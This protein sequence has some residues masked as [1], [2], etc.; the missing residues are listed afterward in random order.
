MLALLAVIGTTGAGRQTG[1]STPGPIAVPASRKATNVAVIPLKGEI[2][3]QGVMAASIRRR[4]EMAE[5]A[6]ADAI[7]IEIDSPGGELGSVLQICN[8]IKSSSI[9]NSVAWINHDAYS[10]GAIVAL[11]CREIVINDPA[12]FGD[13]KVITGGPLGMDPKGLSRDQ[14]KKVLPP[15]IAEVVDSARRHNLEFGAYVWDEYLVQAIV[16]DDVEL[17]LARHKVT[18]QQVCIDR[19]ELEAYF[20]GVSPG[21]PPRLASAPGTGTPADRPFSPRRPSAGDGQVPAGS[22]KLAPIAGDVAARVAAA[23]SRPIIDA[24]TAGEWE[25]VERVT[26]GSAAA[27]FKAADLVHFRI[28]ANDISSVGGVATLVPIRNDADLKAFFGA[29]NLLRYHASWSEGLVVFLTNIFVRGLLIVVFLIAMFV[30]MTH[31]GVIAPGVVAL[32]ALVALLAPPMLIGLAGWWEV[33]AVI[34]GIA[35]LLVELFVIPGF[36]VIGVAGLILLFMGLVGTF[37]P[38][39]GGL[40]PNSPKAQEGLLDGAAVTLLA[41]VTAGLGMWMVAKHFGS[42]PVLGRLVLKTDA[43]S[44]SI[45]VLEAI[46]PD[47]GVTARPGELGVSL[48]PMRPA[49]RVQ[50]GERVVDAVAEFGYIPSGARV[51]VVSADGLKVGVE[52]VAGAASPDH[53]REG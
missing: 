43:D 32:L 48:T 52:E 27:T 30:E 16:A 44:D 29:T 49:G 3:G 13:A 31:P 42:L 26:D 10:G 20:G 6:G 47:A 2:D 28:P 1:A 40:F 9:K 45:G 41:C 53:V 21:G 12:N 15:L 8:L 11:A 36:G 37:I 17:W 38:S 4:I 39:G 51:R 24:A 14:L 34:L 50:I 22:S 19:G 18:G 7:V 35:L 46:D 23:S 33:A 5:R 25:I